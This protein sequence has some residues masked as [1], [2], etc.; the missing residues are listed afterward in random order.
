MKTTTGALTGIGGLEL[1]YQGWLPEGDPKA[2]LIICHGLAEHGGRYAHVAGALTARGCAAWA[3]DYRGHG[4]SEGLRGYVE[5]FDLFTEDLHAFVHHVAPA[6]R[7]FM[8]GHSMG[9]AV[10]LSYALRY[11]QDLDGLIVSGGT[12]IPGAEITPLVQATVK[13]MSSVL[14]KLPVA[15]LPAAALSHDP[16]VNVAYDADPLV[17]RGKVR[18]RLGAEILRANEYVR[19]NLGRLAM[20]ILIMHGGED[21]ITDPACAQILYDGVA[22]ADKTVK[23]WEG[24]YHEIHNEPAVKD[25]VIAMMADWITARL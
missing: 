7:T 5:R 23:V 18:A 12:L 2:R 1:F 20:P 14:P 24:M 11:P 21:S 8:Y 19:A 9:S 10:A 16:A 15:A 25:D 13:L 3:L 6:P 17:Y 22:A 4:R